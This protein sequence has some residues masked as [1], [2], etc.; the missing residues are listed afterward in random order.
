MWAEVIEEQTPLIPNRWY[1][2][3]EN[4]DSILIFVKDSKDTSNNFG[5]SRN[6]SWFENTDRCWSYTYEPQAWRE[7][8][9]EEIEDLL[10]KEA[11]SRGYKEGQIIKSF[12]FGE[13]C[14]SDVGEGFKFD[15]HENRL[16]Y[17][18]NIIFQ[19]G[20]WAEVIN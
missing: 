5:F 17:N 11:R 14:L 4:A 6:G 9:Q 12:V 15:I 2:L 18:D 13:S 19:E 7:A 16:W 1:T 8:T 3:K 10:I 20:A